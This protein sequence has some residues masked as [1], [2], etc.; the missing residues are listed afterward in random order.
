MET[1]HNQLNISLYVSLPLNLLVIRQWGIALPYTLCALAS[2][3][4]TAYRPYAIPHVTK[5]EMDNGRKS[6]YYATIL[7]QEMTAVIGA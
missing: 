6:R 4:S 2:L 7:S 3:G 5:R 1:A